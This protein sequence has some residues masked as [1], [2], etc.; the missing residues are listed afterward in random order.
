MEI[1]FLVDLLIF[2]NNTVPDTHVAMSLQVTCAISGE[3]RN[4][5]LPYITVQM[6]LT[7][8]ILV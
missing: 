4:I 5:N 1:S 6:A 3:L 7:P 8:N 2:S